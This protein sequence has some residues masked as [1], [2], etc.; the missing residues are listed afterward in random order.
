MEAVV[1]TQ[2][3]GGQ[4]EFKVCLSWTQKR[5]L[6]GFKEKVEA[7]LGIVQPS[8]WYKIRKK[9]L[10]QI[11]LMRGIHRF[12]SLI[13][14]VRF[15]HPNETWIQ[16]KFKYSPRMTWQDPESTRSYLNT[17]GSELRV[18]SPEDWYSIS[19]VQV[20]EQVLP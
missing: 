1:S 10:S 15:I 12:L 4:P 14:I 9:D 19:L 8:D 16:G 13:E 20:R 3:T 17:I 5:V 7:H 6:K 11:P 18:H 2:S